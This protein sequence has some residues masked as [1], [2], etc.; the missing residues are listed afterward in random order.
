MREER[1]NSPWS[2]ECVDGSDEEDCPWFYECRNGY[3]LEYNRACDS[4]MDCDD[5]EDEEFCNL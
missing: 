5:G 1:C 2:T 4:F 3:K